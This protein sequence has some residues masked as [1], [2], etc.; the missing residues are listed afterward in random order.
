MLSNGLIFPMA[1]NSLPVFVELA[2]FH[3]SNV[4][5]RSHPFTELLER[6]L[7]SSQIST[8]EFFPSLVLPILFRLSCRHMK[9]ALYTATPFSSLPFCL[10]FCC[11]LFDSSDRSQKAAHAPFG[12]L[13]DLST[14][15][16]ASLHHSTLLSL[17]V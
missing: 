10:G 15:I 13:C 2:L 3:Y 5:H 6:N 1:A 16:Y 14:V 11:D 12:L 7:S 17:C 4:T 9:P 8:M